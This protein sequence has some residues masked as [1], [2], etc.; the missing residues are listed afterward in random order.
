VQAISAVEYGALEAP[1]RR[2]PFRA[3]VWKEWRQQRWIF[4]SLAGL[5][6]VLLLSAAISVWPDRF[7]V[8]FE[9]GR[10][11][12][13]SVLACCAFFLGVCSVVILSANAF[14]GERDD[15]TDLFLETVPCSRSKLFWVKLGFVLLL[16]LLELI[17]AGTALLVY[18]G[19]QPNVRPDV[20]AVGAGETFLALAAVVLV[21]AIIPA[22][23]A[24]F[25]GSVIA[26]ILAS[27]PA[28]G[29]CW[30]YAYSPLVL[31]NFLPI[32]RYFADR[33]VWMIVL[34]CALV[35]ATILLAAWR[36]WIRIERTW[37]GALRTS[38]ATAGLLIGYIVVPSLAAY[39]YVT[40]FAPLSFFT[41]CTTFIA[42]G[43]ISNVCPNGKHIAFDTYYRGWR[44]YL[45][46]IEGAS[47]SR[48]AL[49]DVNFDRTRWLT[50]F[51]ESYMWPTSRFW[52]PS[53]NLLVLDEPNRWLLWPLAPREITPDA[54][55]V[56][57]ARSGAKLD[58]TKFC[59]GLPPIS[60]GILP[61]AGW[62]NEQ[63]FALNNGR[64]IFFADIEHHGVRQCKMPAGFPRAQLLNPF[65][66]LAVT[67]RGIYACPED[68][69]AKREM[70]VLRYAPD[71][72]EAE[73]MTLRNVSGSS[74]GIKASTD[75]QWL[76][77]SMNIDV[78]G[79]HQYPHY[80]TPPID[81]AKAVLLISGNEKENGLIP[82]SWH[83]QGFLP[84][85][86]QILLY[87]DMELGL[88]DADTHDLRRIS[89]AQPSGRQIA[90]V[91]LSP[92]GGFAL[93]GLGNPLASG[94]RAGGALMY[95]IA[96]LHNGTSWPLTV[97]P[98]Q[99]AFWLGEDHL[100][101][102]KYGMMPQIMNRDGTG[103]HPLLAN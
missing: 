103:V 75:G 53:G 80:L 99:R 56:V 57:D 6:Y 29:A 36:M 16:V 30:A 51:R 91:A 21:L 20:F 8:V 61:L 47:A 64:D 63:V 87:S 70:R 78:L 17:P 88:F 58:L 52:S 13:A 10:N 28:I 15:N 27:L 55:F 82:P 50:R 37:R 95:A 43:F 44:P 81:E 14:C 74:P 59:P 33:Y 45:N 84:G 23:I 85:G 4:L 19:S 71:L 40:L 2:S 32:S 86:H 102:Q 92:A 79:Q 68:A 11:D 35:L 66:R 3:L 26:T 54:Y 62:Y 76:L 67:D 34:F 48:A 97:D 93:V 24:S 38:A 60:A 73:S 72:P 94:M 46:S 89:M 22:M 98:D 49:Q 18:I 5:T 83:E 9:N 1:R 7:K 12:G 90:S 69:S 42:G 31:V 41:N 65:A 39:L 96:D 101:L 77:V 100:L 25:G